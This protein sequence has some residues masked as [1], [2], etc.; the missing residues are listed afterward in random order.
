MD[1]I[2]FF[3]SQALR[4]KKTIA[5]GVSD[6]ISSFH[7]IIEVCQEWILKSDLV[8]VLIGNEQFHKTFIDDLPFPLH[9]LES[10]S[11]NNPE[12]FL[13]KNLMEQKSIL[14]DQ[15]TEIP[16]IDSVIRGSLSSSK[17]LQAL[18]NH[19]TN[20]PIVSELELKEESLNNSV[21]RLALLETAFGTQF[22]YAG[23]GIDEVNSYVGKKNIL[24]L[25]IKLFS[26]FKVPPNVSVLSGG[27]LSDLG[28]DPNIDQ[29]ITDGDNLVQEMKAQFPHIQIQ[30][31]QILIENALHR[32]A[33][34]VLAPEGIAG[35]LIYRTLVHLGGG[36]SYGAIY[37]KSYLAYHRTIIDCSRVAPK[38]EIDGAII[39]AAAF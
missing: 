35:N 5:I 17:F 37:L 8:F 15:K 4:A 30:H 21:S 13:I 11:V 16:K 14:T 22:F 3:K 1:F 9:R 34:I 28:R 39:L 25:S 26:Q 31:D 29:T 24:E 18:K 36:K 20:H 23:V 6:D 32:N 19:Y 12:E 10:V 2:N 33:N 7:R 38:F 27:R